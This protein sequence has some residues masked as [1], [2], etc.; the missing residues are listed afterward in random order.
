MLM[1]TVVLR[2]SPDAKTYCNLFKFQK[3]ASYTISLCGEEDCIVMRNAWVRQMRWRF[4]V[5]LAQGRDHRHMFKRS[6]VRG[7]EEAGDFAVLC[8][9]SHA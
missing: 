8:C 9:P 7:C 1:S 2:A 5:W 4:S 6:D 3:S